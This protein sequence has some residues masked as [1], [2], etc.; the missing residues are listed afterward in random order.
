[1]T[2]IMVSRTT[3]CISNLSRQVSRSV[4]LRREAMAR[5]LE[6]LVLELLAA[7]VL[8]AIFLVVSHPETHEHPEVGQLGEQSS[9]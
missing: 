3:F 4:T 7:I 6:N 2:T 1:M 5:R 8:I 9:Y